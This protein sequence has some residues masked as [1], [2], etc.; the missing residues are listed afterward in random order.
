MTDRSA[1]IEID[2]CNQQIPGE[3]LAYL[4]KQLSKLNCKNELKILKLDGN[5]FD[6]EALEQM[7]D[8]LKQPHSF[9]LKYLSLANNR[10]IGD[11]GFKILGDAIKRRHKKIMKYI[12]TQPQSLQSYQ[13]PFFYLDL[14]DI[15]LGDS[16]LSYL[17]LNLDICHKLNLKRINKNHIDY[18]E[19]I[20]LYLANNYLTENSLRELGNFLRFFQ[21]ISVLDISGAKSISALHNDHLFKCLLENYS[22]TELNMANIPLTSNL[23]PS[24]LELLDTNFTLQKFYISIDSQFSDS[25]RNK[26]SE[27]MSRWYQVD[28]E[29]AHNIYNLLQDQQFQFIDK[30]QKSQFYPKWNGTED[31]QEDFCQ[32][33]IYQQ[34]D[35]II[36]LINNYPTA[37]Q[38][39]REEQK[40][41]KE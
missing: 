31:E 28:Y 27:K 37:E 29:V 30:E 21:G 6:R 38:K 9:K 25:L 19:Y 26:V 15:N 24:L 39:A 5:K 7:S 22:L 20:Q 18:F 12:L 1:L 4:F 33:N 34:K 41:K 2:L 11:N 36:P 13:L 35:F 14:S 32:I 40:K 16:G 23:Q 17:L 8:Y 10:E 3:I